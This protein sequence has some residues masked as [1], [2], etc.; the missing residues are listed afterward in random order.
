MSRKLKIRWWQ[1]RV[2]SSPT[3]GTSSSQ[4]TY[5]LRRAFSF[6]DKAH[7]A[8]I[9]LL[10]ASNRDPLSLGSRLAA[11]L[12]AAFSPERK[13]SI[14]TV[15]STW[16]QSPLCDHVF[17]CL[18]QKRRH[19]PAPLLL[20]SKSQPLTLG[21]DLVLGANPEVVASILFR[22]SSSSQATYRLRRAF[23]FHCKAHR[24]RILPLLASN[25]APLS[26]GGGKEKRRLTFCV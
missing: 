26:L 20:L 21:C 11:A 24:A 2:G 13:I 4:A 9:L 23:S 1:H 19:P 22:Y 18:W 15:P 3:T 5:R 8:L 16:S 6:H 25:R 7:R 10:L 14:L 12:R 17:L